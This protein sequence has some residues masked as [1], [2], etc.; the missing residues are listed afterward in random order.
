LDRISGIFPRTCCPGDTDVLK[1]QA[2]YLKNP[3]GG[4]PYLYS[5]SATSLVT[6]KNRGITSV[7][8]AG[9]PPL[10]FKSSWIV[11]A[12]EKFMVV[13][14]NGDPNA[15]PGTDAIDDGRWVPSPS[16]GSGNILSGRHRVT[17]GT[18]MAVNLFERNGRATCVL[19]DGHVGVFA[20]QDGHN[21]ACFDPMR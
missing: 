16:A 18:K 9:A 15:V 10:H 6:D 17:T 12:S 8:A 21:P 4:N 11:N 3:K 14:E 20:P 13:E 1:R 19:A 7:Y 2:A 5:Y